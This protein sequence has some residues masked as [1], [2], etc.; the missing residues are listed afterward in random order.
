MKAVV[1][2]LSSTFPRNG[3]QFIMQVL[4]QSGYSNK[5]LHH[6]NRV[7]VSQ[8]LLFMSD[9]LTALGNKIN[10]EVLT[11]RSPGEAWSNMTWP[12]KHP[13]ESD[14]QLW[15][16]D[17]LSICPSQTNHTQVGRFTGPTHRIWQWTWN[18]D[19]STLHHLRADGVTEDVFVPSRKPNRFH[20]S[21]CQPHSNL[22]TICSVEPTLGGEGWHLTSSEP[23]ARQAQRLTSFLDIPRSGGNTWLW[24][25]LQVTGGETW[26][27]DSIA[28]SLLVAVTD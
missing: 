16:R 20:H 9:V 2:N 25:H 14:F 18:K 21:H 1:A 11:R 7:R 15:W 19:K 13:P 27:H 3:N 17:M 28:D 22:N 10:P 5:V 12:T 26:I 24:E 6:L 23:C 8:Q 4:I